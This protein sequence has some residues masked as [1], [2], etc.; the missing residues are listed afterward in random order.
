MT[1]T[2]LA[3]PPAKVADLM[4]RAALMLTELRTDTHASEACPKT[5]LVDA[6]VQDHLDELEGLAAG[7]E[8]IAHE[9]AAQAPADEGEP[10]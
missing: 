7:L 6:D 9:A 2:A 3:Y 8:L 10:S 5:G 4:H 1:G